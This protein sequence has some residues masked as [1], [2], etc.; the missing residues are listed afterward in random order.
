MLEKKKWVSGDERIYFGIY[1][2]K[3]A[4]VDRFWIVKKKTTSTMKIEK[5]GKRESDAEK[6]D[7]NKLLLWFQYWCWFGMMLD[8]YVLTLVFIAEYQ[9][10][11][12]LH[13]PAKCFW[14]KPVSSLPWIHNWHCEIKRGWKYLPIKWAS[15]R[16]L[17]ANFITHHTLF[18][19]FTPIWYV[20]RFN[21]S[22]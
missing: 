16:V 11:R 22:K 2:T 1:S 10:V 21:Y 15:F 17:G 8:I 13:N 5:W 20:S 18:A 4:L 3:C 9:L 14:K 19:Y 6:S 12:A 7:N